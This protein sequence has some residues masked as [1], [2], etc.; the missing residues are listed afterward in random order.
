MGAACCS[1]AA[2]FTVRRLRR[3]R[4]ASS[5]PPTAISCQLALQTALFRTMITTLIMV[6]KN[7]VRIHYRPAAG[8][9]RM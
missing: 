9:A 6:R 7:K 4:A 5:W 1:A 8:P 3:R 2:R